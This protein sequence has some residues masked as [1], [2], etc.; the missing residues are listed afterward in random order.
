MECSIPEKNRQNIEETKS[1]LKAFLEAQYKFLVPWRRSSRKGGNVGIKWINTRFDLVLHWKED[2]FLIYMIKSV[3]LDHRSHYLKVVQENLNKRASKRGHWMTLHK[4]FSGKVKNGATIL[5][6]AW[7][8]FPILKWSAVSLT[9]EDNDN[10]TRFHVARQRVVERRKLHVNDKH[11]T[12]REMS[13]ST[14]TEK[15]S[16]I[17]P[18]SVLDIL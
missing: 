1:K 5:P 3:S 15:H 9:A 14:K 4:C 17:A 12:T 2:K 7:C 8:H 11:D 18:L 10:Y 6:F 16:G 13:S